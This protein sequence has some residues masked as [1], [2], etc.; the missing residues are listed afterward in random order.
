MPKFKILKGHD[1]YVVY[2]AIIEADTVEQ[3]NEFAQADRYA[4]GIW[5]KTGEVREFDKPEIFEEE[6]E[7]AEPDED[8][9][10]DCGEHYED[11]GDG[12]NGRCPDCADKAE[13]EGRSDD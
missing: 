2:E 1:A 9:C 4:S 13:E 10:R 7:L 8:A 11:G 5:S 12:Y 3:A 6:T